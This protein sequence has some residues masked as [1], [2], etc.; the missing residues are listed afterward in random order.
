MSELRGASVRRNIP[1][2]INSDSPRHHPS[3]HTELITNA[4]E[5][6]ILSPVDGS[7]QAWAFMIGAFMI[8]GLMWGKCCLSHLDYLAD[9]KRF[10]VDIWSLSIILSK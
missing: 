3:N 8:E 1:D 10:P 2:R 6:A 4:N 7:P 5:D 9:V